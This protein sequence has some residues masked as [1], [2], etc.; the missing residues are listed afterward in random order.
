MSFIATACVPNASQ[1]QVNQQ[2]SYQQTV[3]PNNAEMLGVHDEATDAESSIVLLILQGGPH[4]ELAFVRDGRSIF[5]YLPN[6][7]K[8]NVV[9]LHQS[10]T[11]NPDLMK[12]GRD[13]TL[14]DAEKEVEISA[15][16][17]SQAISYYTALNKDIIVLSHSYGSF[18][19]LKHL[20][21]SGPTATQ[22]A[23]LAGRLDVNE[24]LVNIHRSGENVRFSSDGVSLLQREPRDS[25]EAV[26]SRNDYR[27][28]NL[29]KAAIGAPRY[30][31]DLASLDL[32]NAV[33][34]FA[35]NDE[36]VGA[37]TKAEIKVLR[38]LGAKV[39]ETHDG[40]GDTIKRFIDKVMDGT[41]VLPTPQ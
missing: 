25:N 19:T 27:N 41:I 10:Q 21:A 31:A 14:A 2:S 11:I 24:E 38:A 37:L 12:A 36:A 39:V 28:G 15:Q 6:Y 29:L 40:H 33:F 26:S 1:E 3:L 32:S 17:L 20:Q 34:I 13:F 23:I 18:I 35:S 5:R 7:Q 30:S 8:Y 22:Y 9:Y 4:D 16:I